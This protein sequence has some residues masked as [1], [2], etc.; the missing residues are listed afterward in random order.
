MPKEDFVKAEAWLHEN[1]LAQELLKLSHLKEKTFRALL[2]HS[3]SKDSTFDEIAKR[4]KIQQPGAWKCWQR[5]N[6]SIMRSF[7]T[8]KL[9]LYAGIL[10]L[11]T[12][13][14]IID[15]LLDYISLKQG[16]IEEEEFRD[17]VERRMIDLLRKFQGRRS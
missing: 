7:F 3:W 12:A 4:L 5:G 9:A 8:L 14:L 17:R 16:E 13:Q 11:E 10:D 6:D 15:D 2:Y 1:L